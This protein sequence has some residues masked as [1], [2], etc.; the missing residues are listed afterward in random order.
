MTKPFDPLNDIPA[1]PLGI[2]PLA[3]EAGVESEVRAGRG[4]P[5]DVG[6]GREVVKGLGNWARSSLSGLIGTAGSIVPGDDSIEKL[7]RSRQAD[8][9]FRGDARPAQGFW[10]KGA[11]LFGQGI[12]EIASFAIPQAA[13]ARGAAAAAKGAAGF[14]MLNRIDQ[15]KRVSKAVGVA[16]KATMATVIAARGHG[17]NY[18]EY[19]D[20]IGNSTVSHLAAFASDVLEYIVER[21]GGPQ[22]AAEQATRSKIIRGLMDAAEDSPEVGGILKQMARGTRKSRRWSSMVFRQTLGETVEDDLS[23]IGNAMIEAIVTGNTTANWKDF[24][25]NMIDAFGIALPGALFFGTS[26]YHGQQVQ[27]NVV[28]ELVKPPAAKKELVKPPAA[29]DDEALLMVGELQKVMAGLGASKQEATKWGSMF[30]NVAVNLAD[31]GDEGTTPKSFFEELSV[32]ILQDKAVDFNRMRDAANDEERLGYLREVFP[33][34]D[35]RVYKLTDAVEAET[36]KK[37]NVAVAEE[38]A[39][40]GGK[41]YSE[42]GD[43]IA[44]AASERLKGLEVGPDGMAV[45]FDT[46][47]DVGFWRNVYAQ[48]TVEGVEIGGKTYSLRMFDDGSVLISEHKPADDPEAW[49]PAVRERVRSRR[50]RTHTARLEASED[51]LLSAVP[52]GEAG[53]VVALN[54]RQRKIATGENLLP[55]NAVSIAERVQ[56]IEAA[57]KAE[58]ARPPVGPFAAGAGGVV[59][60]PIGDNPLFG[61]D[62]EK[63]R[64]L[65]SG[66]GGLEGAQELLNWLAR[67]GLEGTPY[68]EAVHGMAE[69]QNVALRAIGEVQEALRIMEER[70]Q[71]PP[72]G[73]SLSSWVAGEDAFPADVAEEKNPFLEL[74][75]PVVREAAKQGNDLA[76]E[77][78][79]QLDARGVEA[80]EHRVKQADKQPTARQGTE[81]TLEAAEKQRP[82][83][84]WFSARGSKLKAAYIPSAKMASFYDSA[85]AE[86]VVHEWIHHT[87]SESLLPQRHMDV[88]LNEY[89]GAGDTVKTEEEIVSAF[90]QFIR[91]GEMPN[92]PK[93][94]ETMDYLADIMHESWQATRGVLTP[95]AGAVFGEWFGKRTPQSEQTAQGRAVTEAT[96][97]ASE[98]EGLLASS[99]SENVPGQDVEYLAAV[100][101]GDTATQQRMVDEAARG[102]GLPARKATTGL[103]RIPPDEFAELG[104]PADEVAARMVVEEAIFRLPDGGYL[105]DRGDVP[106]RAA[107]G[108]LLGA[109]VPVSLLT[110]IVR[111]MSTLYPD[112]IKATLTLGLDE[113]ILQNQ[114]RDPI[115]RDYAGKVIPL[116]QRFQ[117][118]EQDIR[119]SAAPTRQE[120]NTRLHKIFGNH[121]A[122]HNA[123]VTKF[124][125]D[126]MK[127]LT[128]EQMAELAK[129]ASQKQRNEADRVAAALFM[130]TA[131]EAR[132][133]PEHAAIM[134][135]AVRYMAQNQERKKGKK[136][137]SVK[138]SRESKDALAS[139][140]D[141]RPSKNPVIAQAYGGD[142]QHAAAM[143]R[144]ERLKASATKFRG[145]LLRSAVREM[146]TDVRT[147]TDKVADGD[148][149]SPWITDVYASWQDM[150]R[151]WAKEHWAISQWW[152]DAETRLGSLDTGL[153]KHVELNGTQRTRNDVLLMYLITRGDVTRQESQKLLAANPEFSTDANNNQSEEIFAANVAESA[154]MVAADEGLART[155]KLLEE[156]YAHVYGRVNGVHKRLTAT[157]DAPEGTPLG[158]VDFYF[159]MIRE[160]GMFLDE[161]WLGTLSGVTPAK[162]KARREAFGMTR[163]RSMALTNNRIQTNVYQVLA[164]YKAQAAV[165]VSKQ[166]TILRIGDLLEDQK[167]RN[168]MIKRFGSDE[169]LRTMWTMLERERYATSRSEPMSNIEAVLKTVR[170][171]G[172]G[173]TLALNLPSSVRQAFS[174]FD[175]MGEVDNSTAWGGAARLLGNLAKG[176]KNLPNITRAGGHQ[177]MLENDPTWQ[178][179]V[180]SGSKETLSRFDPVDAD[181]SASMSGSIYNKSVKGLPIRDWLFIGQRLFDQATRTAAWGATYSHEH[182]RLLSIGRSEEGAHEGAFRMA[183]DALGATQP[184]TTTME[185]TLSQS[186]SEWVRILTPYT[187]QLLKKFNYMRGKVIRPL[188]R[189]YRNTPGTGQ[190][191]WGKVFETFMKSNEFTNYSVGRK[192]IFQYVAPVMAF[193]LLARGRIPEDWEEFSRDMIG[194]NMSI[195]PVLGPAMSLYW[196]YDGWDRGS[197]PM[198]LQFWEEAGSLIEGAMD[199]VKEDEWADLGSKALYTTRFAGL[200]ATLLRIPRKLPGWKENDVGP[201]EAFNE[202]LFKW[203]PDDKGM[204][205]A[206]SDWEWG[207]WSTEE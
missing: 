36:V 160:G 162:S 94:R 156:F 15:A 92:D 109:D 190:E 31:L 99:V 189:A 144:W 57:R 197:S 140:L 155:A 187:G 84:G 3:G 175:W 118:G 147:M 115:T 179:M 108:E 137:E 51:I 154:R 203:R 172:V 39:K 128:D 71:L 185:R 63:L 83:G 142:I 91:D 61:A 22:I 105:L 181:M 76:V 126:S 198:Y 143:N 164:N 8:E 37:E 17:P 193:G 101:K 34:L 122:V 6:P 74:P 77:A 171:H 158:K 178:L 186:S 104:M 191:K 146:F 129:E 200:P 2:D 59:P 107:V 67:N 53:E 112:S 64:D 152:H 184:G 102:A 1:A 149:N 161:D 7:Y 138:A 56:A 100:E 70:K 60:L 131:E 16:Q 21:G 194:Y 98:S 54:M 40:T 114:S 196:L 32:A 177:N 119:F 133:N 117:Q 120:A 45:Q 73:E 202:I 180:K 44:E 110:K 192:M 75:Y 157:K 169:V 12:G 163:Q 116:S 136:K 95:E 13:A 27:E 130:E 135:R 174:I 78:K 166:E 66:E 69:D 173:G 48:G 188:Y 26:Q 28:K 55:E 86:D 79:K 5:M 41:W 46:V 88:L 170:T 165:Y 43:K 38:N 153:N 125:V 18:Y 148:M 106:L 151:D 58:E 19:L 124:G 85:T 20:K 9:E 30:Y 207:T 182:Q 87:I 42:S 93:L 139:D 127:D 167:V 206:L 10:N 49:S 145:G 11:H 134:D 80:G 33:D 35:E 96:A 89:R 183:E 81:A 176:T 204:R 47:N 52:Q 150:T 25:R 123:A 82:H 159:P 113:V 103:E 23:Y 68:A 199:G 72:A 90:F 205:E 195:I 201:L 29:K 50:L 97:E 24:W 14:R 141:Q 111:G 132:D 65:A 121:Q 168:S 4:L 62:I